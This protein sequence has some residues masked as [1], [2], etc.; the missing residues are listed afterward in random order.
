MVEREPDDL[1]YV[2]GVYR[3]QLSFLETDQRGMLNHDKFPYYVSVRTG[4]KSAHVP[5][6]YVFTIHA[7]IDE[8]QHGG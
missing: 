2:V 3:R 4:I 6:Q 1:S 8:T 7:N 5:D